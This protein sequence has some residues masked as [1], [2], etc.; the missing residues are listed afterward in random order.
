[1]K[2]TQ[3]LE[4]PTTKK[5]SSN[6]F[7][8]AQQ[9]APEKKSSKKDKETFQVK[10]L[11][12][13]LSRY[14]ELKALIKNSEAEMEVIAGTIKQAGKEKFLEVFENKGKKPESFHIADG[15]E[16]VLYIVQDA[17]K[18]DRSGMS[19]EKIDL[20]ADHPEI[21]ETTTTFTFNPDVVNR[22]GDK[23]SQVIM[24]SKLISDEDKKNLI[25]ATS[26]TTIKKGT[27]EKLMEFDNPAMMFE[28]IEPIVAL[29]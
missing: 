10:G 21:L 5:A 14:E 13:E 2:H 22:I 17:Y 27:I 23:L 12:N 7:A 8:I 19:Q 20:F 29:K 18:G 1:M 6:L 16:K 25:I 4:K 28:L 15:E 3:T 9:Q 26:K 11:K 24:S